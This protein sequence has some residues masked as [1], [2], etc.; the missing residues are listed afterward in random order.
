MSN[1]FNARVVPAAVMALALAQPSIGHASCGAAF[2]AVNSNWDIQGAW[3]EPGV[4]LDL[5]YEY[6]DQNQPRSGSDKVSVGQIPLHHD[7]IKTV[8]R[9]LVATLDYTLDRTW[10]LSVQ[11]PVTDRTH[12][13]VHNHHG[14]QIYDAWD[15]AGLGDMRLLGRYRSLLD[16]GAWGLTAGFKLPT[17]DIDKTNS[18]G[19]L[20]ERTLQLGSGT[21]D[22]LAGVYLNRQVL[23]G[24]RPAAWFVQTQAQLPLAERADFQPGNQL[25]VDAGVS[26]PVTDRLSGLLQLNA[27]IKGRDSGGEAE[28][29]DS[30]G[31]FVS[32]SP[33]LGYALTRQ[34]R[35]YGFVQVPVYQH[36]N[37][38]QLTADRSLVVGIN[39]RL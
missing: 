30:G 25:F 36:V 38:V 31:R 6:V 8:N 20:A 22:L 39:Y 13:H 23:I 32:L 26:Y 33:G 1:L 10:G 16:G 15:L 17:G 35:I 18:A 29:E 37:G 21:T 27:H 3:T 24:T 11:L 5:R 12:A 14:A 9:N 28:P 19:K 2:C 4:R 7:E 34:L